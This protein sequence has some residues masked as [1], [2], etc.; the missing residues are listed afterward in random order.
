[1]DDVK[2]LKLSYKAREFSISL[3]YDIFI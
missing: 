1:M 3:D 2:K